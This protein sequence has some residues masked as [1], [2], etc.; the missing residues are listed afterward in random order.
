MAEIVVAGQRAGADRDVLVIW[1]GRAIQMVE[2][3]AKRSLGGRIA[4]DFDLAGAPTL[5]PGGCMIGE[6]AAPA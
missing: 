6:D 2:R 4:I 3:E 5:T 1:V